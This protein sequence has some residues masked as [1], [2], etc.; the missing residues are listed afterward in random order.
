MFVSLR[1]LARKLYLRNPREWRKSADSLDEA[2][3]VIFS[4]DHGWR[5][6]ELG[7]RRDIAALMLAFAPDFAGDRVKA[8]I[9]GLSSMVQTAFGNQVGFY[10]LNELEPQAFYNASRNVEIAAWKLATARG[11]DGMPLL[12]S[13]EMGEITN[14]SFE[15]EFGR[16][17]GILETLTD[18]VEIKTERTVVR[19]VQNLA[20]AVFLPIP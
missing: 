17:I 19:I 6:E 14:L 10:M 20:T 16:I 11:P 4:F 9:V 1:R 8:F 3:G 13:N 5:F 18:V 2:L 12:L 7:E 15:R